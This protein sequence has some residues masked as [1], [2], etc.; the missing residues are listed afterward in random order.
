MRNVSFDKSLNCVSNFI[1]VFSFRK[2]GLN[3]LV[4][5]FLTTFVFRVKNCC[6]KLCGLAFDKV[7]S[8]LSEQE[9]CVSY[10]NKL[11]ITATPRTLVRNESEIRVSFFTVATNNLRIVKLILNQEIFHIFV[12][13]VDVNLSESVVKRGFLD[14]VLV[15]SF[16]ESSKHTEFASLFKLVNELLDRALSQRV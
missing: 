1:N 4:N 14:S 16:E 12:T 8:L 6:P 9:I 13:S 7:A 11:F 10:S 3:N 15:S 5:Y 2:S